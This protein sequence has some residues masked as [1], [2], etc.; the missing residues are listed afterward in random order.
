M[1]K[2]KS[3]KKIDIEENLDNFFQILLTEII[4]ESY[5]NLN[6]IKNNN[7]VNKNYNMLENDEQILLKE[8]MDQSIYITHQL[9][10]LYSVN[11]DIAKFI[12]TGFLFNSIVLSIPNL[13]DRNPFPGVIL[14]TIKPKPSGGKSNCTSNDLYPNNGKSKYGVFVP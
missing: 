2:L 10:D 14:L 8:I 1:I 5:N 3:G 7:S 9:F 11:K 6:L 4:K 12:T 13:K